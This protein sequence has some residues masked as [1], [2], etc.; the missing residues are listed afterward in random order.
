MYEQKFL[1]NKRHPEF[2]SWDAKE[3]QVDNISNIM[4]AHDAE[5]KLVHVS[6]RI[7]IIQVRR[8]KGLYDGGCQ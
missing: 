5:T 3:K 8:L 1:Q 2:S 6:S 4:V 7:M